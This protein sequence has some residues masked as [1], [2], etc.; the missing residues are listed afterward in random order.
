LTEDIT[1]DNHEQEWDLALND[2]E[3]KK[4]AET[5][6]NQ[7]NT[8]DR[9][10]HDRMIKPLE[11]IISYNNKLSW[12]TIGDGRFGT[13]ANALMKLGADNVTC[14]DISDKLLKIGNEI[15]FIKKYSAQNAEDLSFKNEEFD[16]VL[17]KEAYH[18]F[19]RPHIAL[20]EMLR[21]AKVGVILIE[22][23]DQKIN[24]KP[25]NKLFPIIK[26]ILGVSSDNTGHG[27]ESVGNYVFSISE[28]ELEKVQLGMHRRHLA[29]HYINDYY[30]SG[31]EFLH[32]DT[33]DQ[34]EQKKINKAKSS[35]VRRDRLVKY[36]L[37]SPDL[38]ASILFKS[39]PDPLILKSLDE[40]GWRVKELPNNPYI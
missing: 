38:L 37:K 20:H 33:F 27:F 10:R 23:Y 5:W 21:V 13:D 9:W 24:P 39:N 6:I 1:Y 7:E 36:G 16:F 8:L 28:R 25:I 14:T 15:G 11:P 29:F 31:F 2:P 19:P 35:I 34:S 12:V 18:H 40:A 4:I 22:P 17:C 30:E 32:L 26:K 3:T